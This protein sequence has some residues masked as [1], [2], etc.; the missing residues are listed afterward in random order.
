MKNQK[1]DQI[2]RYLIINHSGPLKFA[3]LALILFA[4]ASCAAPIPTPT[5][6]ATAT[7]IPPTPTATPT[8]SPTPSPVPTPTATPTPIPTPTPTATPIPIPPSV[9]RDNVTKSLVQIKNDNGVSGTGIILDVNGHILTSSHLVKRNQ[10]VTVAFSAVQTISAAVIG[11]DEK[12][13]IA[14]LKIERPNLT[15]GTFGT[16]TSL[17]LGDDVEAI[18]ITTGMFGN[19]IPEV[20]KD[21]VSSIESPNTDPT[22]LFVITNA[23]RNTNFYGAPLINNQGEIVAMGIQNPLT[24]SA[25]IIGLTIDVIQAKV[26]DLKKGLFIYCATVYK[27]ENLKNGCTELSLSPKVSGA[28]LWPRTYLKGSVTINGLPAPDNTFVFA[29]IGDFVSRWRTV[30]DG[31]YR[32]LVIDPMSSNLVNE[33]IVFYINGYVADQK[34]ETFEKG[35]FI[36]IDDFPL[37]MSTN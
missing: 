14:I 31:T 16:L 30:T 23:F 9:I 34:S 35:F 5:P 3:W 18:A 10:T 7:A 11:V 2:K 19:A 8:P 20:G 13:G 28:P 26:P 32:A 22:K 6:T 27:K 17:G 24:A 12:S 21:L 25:N 4:L 36:T 37:S 29:R 1:L 33:P 15:P